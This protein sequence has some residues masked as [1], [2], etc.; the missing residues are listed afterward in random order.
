MDEVRAVPGAIGRVGA[1]AAGV[2]EQAFLL[3]GFAV[4]AQGLE[5][6][7]QAWKLRSD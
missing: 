6:A 7:S 4:N 1:A 3:G 5:S 2:R